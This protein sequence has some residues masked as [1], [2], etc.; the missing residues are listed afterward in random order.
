MRAYARAIARPRKLDLAPAR[1]CHERLAQL[2]AAAFR[3]RATATLD[4]RLALAL[5]GLG[6]GVVR[7]TLALD[8]ARASLNA[9]RATSLRAGG[10]S[11]HRLGAR[12]AHA[13]GGGS[14]KDAVVRFHKGT[15]PL[16]AQRLTHTC[17]LRQANS[18]GGGQAMLTP[19]IR[20]ATSHDL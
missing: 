9:P 16:A 4:R 2:P 14:P 19:T 3:P 20:T 12:F 1:L 18:G 10:A 7:F 5:T 15:S 6:F 8:F 13:F 11:P 17:C